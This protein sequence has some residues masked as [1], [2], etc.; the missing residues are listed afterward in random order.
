MNKDYS[1]INHTDMTHTSRKFRILTNQEIWDYLDK[2]YRIPRYNRYP[3]FV[4][5]AEHAGL[6]YSYL[7]DIRRK[8]LR[9]QR[10]NR[11]ALSQAILRL[12]QPK[13]ISKK[14]NRELPS[15]NKNSWQNKIEDKIDE[16]LER[17]KTIEMKI[18]IIESQMPD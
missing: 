13:V 1:T 9:L 17:V 4:D 12:G 10:T 18:K 15:R 8:R 6:H 7:H 5:I 2:V 14:E 11:Y 3:R 16:L